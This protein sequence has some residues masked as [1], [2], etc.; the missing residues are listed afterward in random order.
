MLFQLVNVFTVSVLWNSIIALVTYCWCLD[1]AVLDLNPAVAH[2][3]TICKQQTQVHLH[4]DKRKIAARFA[5][6]I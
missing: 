6:R 5:D 4:G 2:R 3:S 1:L